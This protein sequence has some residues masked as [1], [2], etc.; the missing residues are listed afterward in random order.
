MIWATP[1][2]RGLDEPPWHVLRMALWFGLVAGAGE[3]ALLALRKYG[4]HRL[5]FL[6]ADA[7]WMAPLADGVLFLVAG[8]VLLGA[9]ALLRDR[10]AVPALLLL[11][12]LAV[13][14]W[15]LMYDALYRPAAAV[16]AVGIGTVVGRIGAAHRPRFDRL[17]A[18]TLPA[19]VAAVVIGAAIV[20]VPAMGGGRAPA[21]GALAR[22]D[23]PNVLFVVLDTVRAANLS[24]YGYGRPTS[25]ELQKWLRDGVRFEHALATV[26]WTLPSHASMFTGRLPHELSAGWLTPLDGRYP[27]LAETLA[28]AGY[29]TAGFVANARYC[30]RETGLARGFAHYEDYPGSLAQVAFSSSLGRFVAGSRFMRRKLVRKSAEEVNA[31]LLAWLDD[32]AGRQPWFAFLNYLD[33][34]SP[35]QPPAGFAGRFASPAAAELIAP[36][37]EDD[38]AAPLAPEVREAAIA[39]YD[40]SLAYLDSE[41]GT[42]FAELDR[43]GLWKD[44]LVVITSDH[45]EEFG[46]R[47]LYYHGNSLYRSALEV[48]LLLRW[49]GRVPAGAGIAMPVSLKDI[50][51]TVVDLVGLPPTL[52]GQSIA[53]Y[54]QDTGDAS[55]RLHE[56]L[57]MEL[58]YAPG[59]PKDTP[60][61][62]GSMHAVLLDGLRL[63]R[64]GDG[65]EELFAF[66]SDPT[67]A[68]DL[69]GR[70]DHRAALL[71]LRET[72]AAVL[73][74][75]TSPR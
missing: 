10:L 42:L 17:V 48:P 45:G 75:S 27:T 25:P 46:E 36:L 43:R 61:S 73:A 18:R 14:T 71:R 51:A 49:P 67:D 53:R 44:T 20:R 50:A 29:R 68:V 21:S 56:P 26:P 60:I 3:L 6:S 2:P 4:L 35:Y 30:S 11:S 59:L 62:R 63:I 47:G 41:L 37:K 23:S 31:E 19:L 39:R 7:V 65:R 32:R 12:A 15:L 40:E 24:S 38:P 54:W 13:F 9:R 64:N 55:H 72:L 8:G 69:A 33:A 34:H 16:L 22:P 57:L 28:H 66:G 74:S 70:P 5:V 1:G 58:A 52:P